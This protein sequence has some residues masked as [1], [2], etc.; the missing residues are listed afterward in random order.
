MDFKRGMLM[1]KTS[2]TAIEQ[3]SW[4]T[5]LVIHGKLEESI[6]LASKWGYDGIEMHL[7]DSGTIHRKEIMAALK[8]HGIALTSIGTGPSYSQ[9]GICLT[10][11]DFEIRREALRRMRGHIQLGS[12][13]EAVVILGLIK[14]QKKDCADNR[15][16]RQYFDEGM[17]I[18]IKEAERMGVRLVFEV[19]DRF[20]SDWLNTVD[21]GLELLRCLN[22]DCVQLH[23]D[24]FHMNIE[25]PDCGA[26]IRKAGKKVGHIHVADSDRWYPGH[27]HY[28]FN[29]TFAA[30]KEIGYTGAVVLESFQYPDAETAAKRSLEVIKPLC[31]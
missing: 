16:Y 5:P 27:A 22:S 28:D 25:E 23:L 26:S 1:M 31:I 20:E 14:G 18:C 7:M 10:S 13:T 24:T 6:E 30:L 9:E 12:E 3:A 4:S 15:L 11:P 2:I 29:T 8:K 17:D 19:I 21:E